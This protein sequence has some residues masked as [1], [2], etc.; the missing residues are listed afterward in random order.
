VA[1]LTNE[2]R[3]DIGVGGLVLLAYVP[4]QL[5]LLQGPRPWDVSVYFDTAVHPE[6]AQHSLF[7]LRIGLIAPVRAA[8]LLFG[9][10]E[11][12]FYAAPLAF[13]VLLAGAVYGTTLVLFR[14]RWV[15]AAAALVTVLAP[16]YLLN[17]S[18]IFPDTG[19]TAVFAAGFLCL[20]LGA[21]RVEEGE[22][23]WAPAVWAGCAGF[24][25]GW[26][27]LIRDFMPILAPAVLAVI[28]LLRYP[29]RRA[30]LLGGVAVATVALDP[31]YA[32]VQYGRPFLH[33]RA[34]IVN[35]P[36]RPVTGNDK[37]LV[38]HFHR[39]LGD[40]F[41]TIAV[42]PR[43]LLTWQVGWVF[44]VLVAV[45]VVALVV[46]RDRRLVILGIWCFGLWAIMAVLGLGSLPSGR[47]ILNITN[48]RYWYPLL[49]PLA[50]GALGGG[51]LL[52]VRFAP[53]V[54]GVRV[55]HSVPAVLAALALVPGV[56][57]FKNCAAKDVWASEPAP[58]W[59]EL[60]AWLASPEGERYRTIFTDKDTDRLA[61][62]F[63]SSTFGDPSWSG[64]VRPFRRPDQRTVYP[65]ESTAALV[66]IDKDR[67]RTSSDLD[68]LRADW[69]PVFVSDDGAMVVLAHRS[70]LGDGGA[71]GQGSWWQV[72]DDLAKRRAAQG[73]GAN[74]YRPPAD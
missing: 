35:R 64:S 4:L 43:L 9:P 42:F 33:L 68:E 57:E 28:V 46:L 27:V 72:P 39:Q 56:V 52:A 74:P 53:P 23:T 59:H 50:M 29:W 2:R 25:F 21:R 5:W 36:N 70:T 11:A 7:T 14:D 47:W 3:L 38:E 37:P 51:Y 13:G 62:L 71:V 60:R 48:I 22:R 17:S 8:V 32:A 16:S 63:T 30:A 20:V 12:A 58:R 15:A 44:L 66:L 24:L 40:L 6:A 61:P 54:R 69:L 19:G 41:D 67:F 10:S 45:F 31:L 55:A 26:S 49:P 18:F 73:C 1:R 65:P 34:L